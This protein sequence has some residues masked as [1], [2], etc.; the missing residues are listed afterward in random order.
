MII[1]WIR[2]FGFSHHITIQTDGGVEFAASYPGSFERAKR[3]VF[4]PLGVKREVIRKGHPEDNAFVERSHQTDDYEFY[5]P[6]L[7]TIKCEK[8][9]LKKVHLVGVHL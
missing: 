2:S 5:I 4:E 8:D 1:W 9:L 6:Y 7:T 3:Y